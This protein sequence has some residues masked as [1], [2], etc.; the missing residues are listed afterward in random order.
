[1]HISIQ[2]YPLHLKTILTYEYRA[3]GDLLGFTQKFLF[4]QQVIPL[5]SVQKVYSH[6]SI[7]V[8]KRS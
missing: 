7:S 4:T 5:Y 1:M 2:S 8:I 3:L 6:Y